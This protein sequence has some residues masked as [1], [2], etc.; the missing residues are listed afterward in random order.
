[1]KARMKK[2]RQAS[3]EMAKVWTEKS[4]KYQ[5]SREVSVVYYPCINRQLEHPHF[6][7]FPLSSPEGLYLRGKAKA[8]AILLMIDRISV[9]FGS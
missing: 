7:E 3:P 8:R 9:A 2:Y 5:Q 4:P 1:M 6:I